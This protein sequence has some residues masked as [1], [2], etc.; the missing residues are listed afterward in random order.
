[1]IPGTR[2]L[3]NGLNANTEVLMRIKV[4]SGALMN[5]KAEMI[6]ESPLTS[7]K[8]RIPERDRRL[9]FIYTI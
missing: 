7:N 3:L 6:A 1:M 4:P 2:K 9:L 5:S 8:R